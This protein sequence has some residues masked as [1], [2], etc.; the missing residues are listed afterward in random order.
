MTMSYKVGKKAYEKFKRCKKCGEI[1][2]VYHIA[3]DGIFIYHSI[4]NFDWV[5]VDGETVHE[6]EGCNG[7][8]VVKVPDFNSEDFDIEKWE[9]EEDIQ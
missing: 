2:A 7:E 1:F 4:K 9:P 3:Q 8:T 6:S 5:N